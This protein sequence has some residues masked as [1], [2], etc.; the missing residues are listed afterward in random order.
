ME[1]F[2]GVRIRHYHADNG[3]FAEKIFMADVARKGQTISF[4]GVNAHFQNGK[5]ERKIMLLQRF[6]MV[7]TTSRDALMAAGHYYKLMALRS[8]KYDT[9]SKHREKS[10]IELFTRTNVRPNLNHHHHI[11]IQVYV[12]ERI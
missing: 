9:S 10:R 11:G 6:G 7:S 12:L 8:S 1:Q 2:Y 3:R 4:C 5:A